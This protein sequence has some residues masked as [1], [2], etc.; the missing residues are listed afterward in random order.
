MRIPAVLAAVPLA[1]A[2]A[3]GVL[4]AGAVSDH[5]IPAAAGASVIA[6]VAAAG[7]FALSVDDGVV[8]A[9]VVGYAAAGFSSGAS[10]ARSLH[11]PPLASWFHANVG[12]AS[13][14]VTLVGVLRD[15]ASRTESGV[16]MTL[17]VVR[18]AEGPTS[19]GVRIAV[20]GT[21]PAET[22]AQWRAGRTVRLSAL[23]RSPSTFR[24]PGVPDETKA[25][26]LRGIALAGTVKSAALV[27]IVREADVVAETAGAVRVLVRRVLATHVAPLGARSAAIAA[28]ILIGDR[29]GLSDDD[30]RRLQDA[31]T[32]HVIAISGGNIAIF[33]GLLLFAGRAARTP[34][35]ASAVAAILALWF[36]GEIAGGAASVGRAITGATVFLAALALDHRS[37]PLNMLGVALVLAVAVSPAVV[38]DAGFLLSFVAT[39]AIILGVPRLVRALPRGRALAAMPA[40]TLCADIGL[41]PVLATF[42]GR[43]TAAGLVV[44][45]VAIPMM[46]IVQVGTLLLLAVAPFSDALAGWCGRIVHLAA[47]ALVESARL[48]DLAPWLARSVPAPSPWLCVAYYAACLGLLFAR[49]RRVAAAVLLIALLCLAAGAQSTARGLV[50]PPAPGI[51]R[52]VVLDVGQGD[53]TT[54]MFPD[55]TALLI[56]AGGFAG[57]TFDIAGRV[58]V[59]ALHAL[60][61]TRLHAFVLTHGDPDHVGGAE[62]VLRTFAPAA[63]WE[64]VPVPPHP[65]LRAL[66]ARAAGQRLLWRGVRAGD[67]D[68]AGE[69]E[70]RIL[71]PPEPEWERQRVRNDDSIVIELRYRDVS[72]LLPGDIGREV[73]RMLIPSLRLAPTVILKAA[74]HGSATSTS[75][76]F[77]DAT[78]PTAVIF[79]AGRN[80]RFGH[81]AAAVVER[82]ERKGIP[83]FNTATHGAVFVETDGRSVRVWGWAE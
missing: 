8:V 65:A 72:I 16:V 10:V 36:Y 1:A 46:T 29:T 35:R 33:T 15:D 23:V 6:L 54:V 67:A 56:D 11:A 25:L 82:I 27:E 4:L 75:D 73:E 20:G 13:D 48:V 64:G 45:F 2:S 50:A 79:S 32:Y 68:R 83:M 17:D 77:L 22:V 39:A 26:A 37:A 81:P 31:G 71:H 53:A 14:P 51:L 34:I 21:P 5:L 59:P 74:H 58:V 42:F 60:Q 40:A 80:N 78:K 7:F 24:N 63:V 76:E 41:A 28:A 9:V 12:D 18:V 66:A 43:L 70:I 38:R 44:N 62:G 30:Q 55:G 61:V 19:G 69:V 47:S 49:V 57:T 52:V 3:A